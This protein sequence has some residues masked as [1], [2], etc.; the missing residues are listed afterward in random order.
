MEEDVLFSIGLLL[1]LIDV[2]VG[3]P[4]MGGCLTYP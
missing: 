3:R 2:D 4:T 1:D